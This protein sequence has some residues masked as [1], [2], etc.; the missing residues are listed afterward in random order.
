MIMTIKTNQKPNCLAKACREYFN[1]SAK[2]V[3][4]TE[5]FDMLVDGQIIQIETI[6]P[7]EE[8]VQSIENFFDNVLENQTVGVCTKALKTDGNCNISPKKVR[9]YRLTEGEI[10]DVF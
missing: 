5:E 6:K 8:V 10:D 9:I 7:G 4:S 3:F 1:T 2:S